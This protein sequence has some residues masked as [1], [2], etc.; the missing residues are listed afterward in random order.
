M[1]MSAEHNSKLVVEF[2][3]E[4]FWKGYLSNRIKAKNN[5]TSRKIKYIGIAWSRKSNVK[6]SEN[7]CSEQN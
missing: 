6:G 7:L 4:C 1:A 2:D 5:V 3:H